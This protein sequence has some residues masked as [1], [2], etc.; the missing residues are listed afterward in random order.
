MRGHALS[1][2]GIAYPDDGVSGLLN[3]RDVS[4]EEL[5]DLRRAVTSDERHTSALLV[6]VHN[7]E[8]RDQFYPTRRTGTQLTVQ[9]PDQLFILHARANLD[10]DGVPDTPEVLDVC[11]SQLPRTISNPQEMRRGVVECARTCTLWDLG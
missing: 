10:T 5:F 7:Y 3:C 2:H 6:R 8:K 1:V 4:R 9:Q 11:S